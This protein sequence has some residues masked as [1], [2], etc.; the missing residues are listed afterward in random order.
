MRLRQRDRRRLFVVEA[1]Q[2]GGSLGG[3]MHRKILGLESAT[4]PKILALGFFWP[5]LCA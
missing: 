3:S 5:A 4:G 2:Q 1:L